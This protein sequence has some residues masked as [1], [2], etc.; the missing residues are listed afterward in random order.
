MGHWHAKAIK[1]AGGRLRA[2]MDSNLEAAQRLAANCRD[3]ES[4][5]DIEQMLNRIN[6]DVLHVCTPLHSHSRIAKLAIEF[7]LNVIVEKPIT[8]M[9]IDTERLFEQAA[10]RGVLI[11]PVHQFIFQN[12]VQ[13]AIELLPRIGQL[14]HIGGVIC[15]AGE[16]G[17][18]CEQSDTI[19]ADILPHPLSLMQIFLPT[20]LCEKNWVISRPV[21]G[22][23]R[24]SSEISGVSLSIFIS[25]NVRPTECSFQV[26]GTDGTIHIDLFHGF[27]FME[28]GK[29]SKTKKVIHPFELAIRR[30]SAATI[31]LGQRVVHWESAYPG[32][33]QLISL[34]YR[35]VCK[36]VVA[37]ISR[38][39]AVAVAR[40]RDRLLQ[41]S[42]FKTEVGL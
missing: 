36:E 22:E 8:P 13:M 11:C 41:N 26:A 27:A 6:L 39:D 7:G 14:V 32:L 5:S 1:R 24:A 42:N 9:A 4:F 17:P 2:V 34:F 25:M 29:V 35:A 30:W 28:P 31:N 10:D 12:G 18:A 23:L 3:A 38:E 15:S 40:S 20:G 33:N 19:V 21:L 37:P 16:R